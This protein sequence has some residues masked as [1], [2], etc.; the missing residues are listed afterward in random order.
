MRRTKPK[1]PPP[2]PKK[3]HLDRRAAQL[4]ATTIIQS[5]QPDDDELL[6]TKQTSQLLGVSE[7]WLGVRRARGDGPPFEQMSERVIRYR[8]GTLRGWLEKR[9]RLAISEYK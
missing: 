1:W 6:T 2:A 7:Q 9:S 5:V 3:F 8:R 4:A